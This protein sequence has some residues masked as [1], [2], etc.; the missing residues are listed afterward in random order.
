MCCLRNGGHLVSASSAFSWAIMQHFDL[1]KLPLGVQLKKRALVQDAACRLFGVWE[2]LL[3]RLCAETH[4]KLKSY[5]IRNLTHSYLIFQLS[6]RFDF[7]LRTLKYYDCTC[8]ALCKFANDL[9]SKMDVRD[10]RDFA[11]CDFKM[12]FRLIS[13]ITIDILSASYTFHWCPVCS[14]VFTSGDHLTYSCHL[15]LKEI[16]LQRIS[17]NYSYMIPNF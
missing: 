13:Y 7:L 8:C 5:E 6:N 4:L 17:K 9:I 2:L 11:R 10:E 3:W 15:L 14:I 1:Q 12:H 16:S